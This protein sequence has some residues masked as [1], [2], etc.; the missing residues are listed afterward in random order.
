LISILA[1]DRG[2]NC[3]ET[4]PLL[5][6]PSPVHKNCSPREDFEARSLKFCIWPYI[7]KIQLGK[8]C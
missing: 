1:D 4:L 8:K 2:Y 3:I 7:I 5:S 6:G